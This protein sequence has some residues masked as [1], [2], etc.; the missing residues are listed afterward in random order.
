MFAG[1]GGVRPR[2]EPGRLSVGHG[3]GGRGGRNRSACHHL[4]CAGLAAGVLAEG[5]SRETSYALLSALFRAA[6]T[7]GPLLVSAAMLLHGPEAGVVLAA[8]L[9][10]VAALVFSCSG[11][12]VV[13]PQAAPPAPASAPAAGLSPGL[14]TL[15]VSAG[16]LSFAVG[17]TAVAVPGVMESSGAAA[18]ALAALLFGAR[19]WPGRCRNQLLFVQPLVA[20]VA[21]LV[22]LAAGQLWLLVL[23]M[24]LAGAARAPVSI[25]QSSLLDH[26]TPRVR[27]ARSYSMLVGVTLVSHAFGSAAGGVLADQV[28]AGQALVVPALALGEGSAWTIF[29]RRTLRAA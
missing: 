5:R 4:C 20:G 10:M 22:L 9:I 7:I 21:V 12:G 18:L 15:L 19:P 17:V 24:F 23:V 27:L 11:G 3:D 29:R 14:L 2:R 8:V 16:L 1:S 13:G 26:V 25:L 28:R 6:V